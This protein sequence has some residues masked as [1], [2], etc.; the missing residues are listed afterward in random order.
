MLKQ[1]TL[2]NI[3]IVDSLSVSFCRGLTVMTGETGA[4][5][6]ILMES[7]G[8]A[9]GAKASAK[10]ILKAG[11]ERGRIE[12]VFDWQDL[13]QQEAVL[14]LL[15]ALDI[16][17]SED[18]T[19]LILS[20]E[21]SP[22]ATRFRLN[23]IPVTREWVDTLRPYL[24]DF[25][26]Q[27]EIAGL[28]N[29]SQQ[30][31]MLDQL[32]G[33]ALLA[34]KKQVSEAYALWSASQQQL[35]AH[36]QSQREMAQR[37]EFVSFQ[38]AEI[39]EAQ[40]QDPEEDESLRQERE[41]LMH[42]ERLNKLSQQIVAGLGGAGQWEDSVS[43]PDLLHKLQ[44]PMNE[45]AKV[46]DSLAPLLERWGEVQ[47]WVS[48]LSDAWQT[49]QDRLQL[50]PE[51]LNAVVDRLDVLEK[52]K[53]KYGPHLVQVIE[54]EAKL[55][56]EL[57]RYENHEA[58]LLALEKTVSEAQARLLD[59]CAQL[60]KLRQAVAE[61]V[62]EQLHPS[63]IELALPKAQVDVVLT[64]LLTMTSEGA[65]ELEIYFSAN[66]GEPLLPLSKVASGGELSRV[67]LA[68]KVVGADAQGVPV[69]VFDE[70]DTGM[71]GVAAKSVGEKLL[72]LSQSAKILVITHQPI[73]AAL[74]DHHWH[75]EKQVEPTTDGER[76]QVL[77]NNVTQKEKR[78]QVM[79]R[80]ASGIDTDDE[81]VEKYIQRLLS[82]AQLVREK[83]FVKKQ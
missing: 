42:G 74:G 76:V 70:I 67:L 27:H 53:R 41:R 28:L 4:G 33:A 62:R 11:Q 40:L 55:T 61:Q 59:C 31:R 49:Y 80:L 57:S 35:E 79:S 8:L 48:E 83:H 26:A 43:L 39:Q 10:D 68:L 37:S 9:L 32:G 46:D 17:L 36:L 63:V 81:A 71:S 24:V 25:H 15:K 2:E 75:V 5:K 13:P 69:M 12:I 19:E 44:K 54:T 21:V 64:P 50:D 3:A 34:V 29:K 38:L 23:G 18:E 73:I 82:E 58:H 1:V 45:A 77:V 22:S 6:S 78:L 7:I 20:R 56:E 47:A 65:E 60:T 52:L 14:D 66:P 16:E 72:M 30:R 51:S